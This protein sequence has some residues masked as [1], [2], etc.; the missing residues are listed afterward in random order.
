MLVSCVY[1]VC[2]VR[3]ENS[4]LLYS[5]F[6]CI[7]WYRY[8]LFKLPVKQITT[9]SIIIL[10]VNQLHLVVRVRIVKSQSVYSLFMIL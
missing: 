2:D 10:I 9:A 8:S 7:N 1:V 3:V 4:V 5:I 6:L